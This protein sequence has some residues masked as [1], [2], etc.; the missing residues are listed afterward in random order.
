MSTRLPSRSD[1]SDN[2]RKKVE[3]S[4]GTLARSRVFLVFCSIIACLGAC[5]ESKTDEPQVEDSWANYSVEP[6]SESMVDILQSAP[7]IY[8]NKPCAP[9]DPMAISVDSRTFSLVT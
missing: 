5:T 2:D 9:Y 7:A 8:P 3:S 6:P 4:V 1:F